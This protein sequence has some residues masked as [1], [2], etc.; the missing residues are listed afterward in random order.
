MQSSSCLRAGTRSRG[1]GALFVMVD[2]WRR[3]DCDQTCHRLSEGWLKTERKGWGRLG[4]L[5]YFS[6][7][8]ICTEPGTSSRRFKPEF[9]HEPVT[10]NWSHLDTFNISLRKLVWLTPDKTYRR[11]HPSDEWAADV[12]AGWKVCLMKSPLWSSL[13][14]SV[15]TR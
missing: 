8:E 5:S 7:E 2:V 4:L 12:G 11:V 10:A 3:F 15:V 13:W 14:P 1:V 9:Y 6:L